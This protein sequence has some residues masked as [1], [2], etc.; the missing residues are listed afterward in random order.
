VGGILLELGRSVPLSPYVTTISFAIYLVCRGI[1]T[2]RSRRGW[3]ARR[4]AEF[5]NVQAG[6]A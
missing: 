6:T 5:G 3:A 4:D 2:V 1:G